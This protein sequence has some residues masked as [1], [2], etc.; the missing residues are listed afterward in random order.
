MGVLFCK[1]T[2]KDVLPLHARRLD[3]FSDL[4]LI[5][6]HGCSVYVGIAGLECHLDSVLDFVRLGLL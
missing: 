4:F 2:H 5:V 1:G 3:P 6:V